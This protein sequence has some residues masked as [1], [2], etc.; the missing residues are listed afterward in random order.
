MTR[1]RISDVIAF[2][3]VAR[4][5]SFTR[6]AAKIG[7]ST[8]ALSHTIRALE[9]E[10]GVRLLT[11]TTRRVSATEAGERLLH[12]IGPLLAEVDAELDA[13]SDLAATPKGTVRITST[14]YAVDTLLWPRLAPLVRS[15]PELKIDIDIDYGLTDVVA[16]RY[17]LGVRNGDQIAKDMVAVRIGPDRRMVIVGA[18]SYL[19]GVPKPTK[20]EDLLKLN[21]LALRLAGGGL[22]AWELRKGKRDLQVRV[23]GQVKF[24]GSYQILNAALS[25]CGLAF[26]PEDLAEPHVAAGRLQYVLEDWFPTIPG[27]HAFYTRHRQSSRAVALVVEALRYRG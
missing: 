23:D 25:G 3:V 11:R 6:A 13:I 17:D 2:L 22:Y 1:D 14:D 9:T 24:N 4:E 12:S 16:Q 8:S 18:P 19:G 26:V 7:V 15:Y 20:P 21:C 10:M 27:L 5:S